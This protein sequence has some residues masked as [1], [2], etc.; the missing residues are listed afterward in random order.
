MQQINDYTLK[1]DKVKYILSRYS[2]Y[3]SLDNMD[4]VMTRYIAVQLYMTGLF[5]EHKRMDFIYRFI[6][7]RMFRSGI[8]S[9][10]DNIIDTNVVV[11]ATLECF[12]DNNK[13][14]MLSVD[15]VGSDENVRAENKCV[16]PEIMLIDESKIVVDDKQIEEIVQAIEDIVE[17]RVEFNILDENSTNSCQ[18]EEKIF[19]GVYSCSAQEIEN[20]IITNIRIDEDFKAKEIKRIYKLDSSLKVKKM[21]EDRLKKKRLYRS[22]NLSCKKDFVV[23]GNK[24]IFVDHILMSSV[25]VDGDTDVRTQAIQKI[26]STANFYLRRF[27]VKMKVH[28]NRIPVECGYF[29]SE[30][31][32]DSSF[33]TSSIL[34]QMRMIPR[35]GCLYYYYPGSINTQTH[36]QYDVADLMDF[37]ER[38]SFR[39]SSHYSSYLDYYLNFVVVKNKS[40]SDVK[41]TIKIDREFEWDDKKNINSELLLEGVEKDVREEGNFIINYSEDLFR[42]KKRG[43]TRDNYIMSIIKNQSLK[44]TKFKARYKAKEEKE[45]DEKISSNRNGQVD[46][47]EVKYLALRNKINNLQMTSEQSLGLF[48]NHDKSFVFSSFLK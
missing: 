40:Q 19:N 21:Q 10:Y 18:S 4:V 41:F 47:I 32:V 33:I 28:Q 1:R 8:I 48:T 12:M 25:K 46:D 45:K 44:I 15:V 13:E 2:S 43:I 6:N 27:H 14:V 34:E 31:P 36:H 30:K 9:H 37:K 20:K 24:E 26:C 22:I 29:F 7:N 5:N 11:N 39:S 16:I 35:N 23:T 3:L 38:S 42:I 17:E